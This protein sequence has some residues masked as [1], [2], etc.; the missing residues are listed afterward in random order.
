MLICGLVTCAVAYALFAPEASMQSTFGE[1]IAG[2]VAQIVVR[3]WGVLVGLTGIMLIY[4]AFNVLVRR[5][6]LLV[7]VASKVAFIA[8]VLSYGQQFLKFQ[9]G[10]GV[11]I[12]GIMVLLFVAYLVS[13][14]QRT[15]A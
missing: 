13:D 7:A 5:M 4:G 11:V 9:A 1:P 2:P 12:D 15:S 6:V 14:R 10:A 8:L 3:H